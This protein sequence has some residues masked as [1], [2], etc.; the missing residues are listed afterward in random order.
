MLPAMV[1]VPQVI[2]H[3]GVG[4]H[5]TQPGTIVGPGT[6]RT[7]APKSYGPQPQ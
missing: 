1:V 5:G 7:G 2:V 3:G 4:C 6:M